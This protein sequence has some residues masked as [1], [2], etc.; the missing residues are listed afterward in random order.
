[1]IGFHRGL[2]LYREQRSSNRADDAISDGSMEYFKRVCKVVGLDKPKDE[3]I[4]IQREIYQE[5]VKS[6]QGYLGF[7][8]NTEWGNP[9]LDGLGDCHSKYCSGQPQIPSD[10]TW[11]QPK[12]PSKTEA[13][14]YWETAYAYTHDVL[15]NIGLHHYNFTPEETQQGL[16]WRPSHIPRYG[17]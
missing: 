14:W 8:D 2:R 9:R 6:P 3:F 15:L 10:L 13:T 4:R 16:N 11:L 7:I 17:R 1:M 5:Y 12:G